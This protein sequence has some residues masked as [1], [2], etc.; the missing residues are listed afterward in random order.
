MCDFFIESIGVSVNESGDNSS[1][2]K[3]VEKKIISDL[4]LNMSII[5]TFGAGL[6]LLYPIVGELVNNMNLNI[7]M[8][9]EKLVLLTI[10]ASSIIYLE[11]KKTKLSS[12]KQN[13]IEKDCKSML[14][15]LKLSGIGNGIV[16]KLVSS[17]KSIK[18]IFKII[19]K[20]MGHTITWFV[21]MFAY[22][23]LVIPL[24][25]GVSSVVG[26]YNLNLDTLPG[27][28]L[29]L[30]LG[31]ATLVAKNSIIEI[32]NKFKSKNSKINIPDIDKV[33]GDKS[34]NLIKEINR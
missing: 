19:G 27:N 10:A 13:L 15:E 26:K 6:T 20:H 31:V 21:D 3:K 34:V 32:L 33:E 29:G 8:T 16:K 5:T 9:T 23:S 4:K 1:V 12:E 24:L 22:T 7:E 25:N 18:N 11:E 30:G 14:E 17:F 2:Y 28:F